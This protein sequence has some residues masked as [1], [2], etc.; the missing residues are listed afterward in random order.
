MPNQDHFNILSGTGIE[1]ATLGFISCVS[2]HW[3]RDQGALKVCLRTETSE[4][5][6]STSSQHI[7]I[8][9]VGRL[10]IG[11]F[12]NEVCHTL[13]RK[14]KQLSDKHFMFSFKI[15]HT[16]IRSCFVWHNLSASGEAWTGDLLFVSQT[17]NRDSIEPSPMTV[18]TDIYKVLLSHGPSTVLLI[19]LDHW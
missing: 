9:N 19:T 15:T 8:R 6:R 18:R 16:L 17:L 2:S 3:A 13:K 14:K 4:N 10:W 11:Y 12:H 7:A 1:P 5:S